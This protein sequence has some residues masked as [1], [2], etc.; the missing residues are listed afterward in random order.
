MH[1]GEGTFYIEFTGSF[2]RGTD[3]EYSPFC[4]I[5]SLKVLFMHLTRASNAL[6][7]RKPNVLQK[8]LN[9]MKNKRFDNEIDIF[10]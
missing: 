8:Y 7:F 6:L 1:E 9:C 10:G 3:E 5:F 2:L 4:L